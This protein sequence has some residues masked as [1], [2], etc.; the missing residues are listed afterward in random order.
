MQIHSCVARVGAGWIAAGELVRESI[1]SNVHAGLGRA[2]DHERGSQIGAD[3]AGQNPKQMHRVMINPVPGATGH[4]DSVSAKGGAKP[5]GAG[6]LIVADIK[7]EIVMDNVI[8]TA[9]QINP[10]S[11][12]RLDII[13]SDAADF[14]AI[15]GG[16]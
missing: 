1:I 14:V 9:G 3:R 15:D 5:T 8:A 11:R 6:G 13:V 16:S 2:N 7:K 4:P 12:P 10:V